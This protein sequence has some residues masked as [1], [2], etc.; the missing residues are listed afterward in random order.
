VI[1]QKTLI[2]ENG[3]SELGSE[4]LLKVRKKYLS[5]IKSEALSKAFL[6][7]I[8]KFKMLFLLFSNKRVREK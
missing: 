2:L 7:V 5:G 4:I 6:E 3:L 1:A 8:T